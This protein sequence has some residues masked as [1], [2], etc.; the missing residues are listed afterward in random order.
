MPSY[1]EDIAE[2]Q[3]IHIRDRQAHFDT[4]VREAISFFD[5]SYVYVRDGTISH[6]PVAEL[7]PIYADYFQGAVFHEWD[8]LEPPII[9]ISGDGKMAWVVETFRIRMSRSEGEQKTELTS[10]YAG[11]TVY[12]KIDGKWLRVANS[13]T[14][15]RQ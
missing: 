3:N 13:S 7:E 15:A 6:L 10:V 1:E 5:D 9:H 12:E 2:L 8:D 11:M 4:N 14:F